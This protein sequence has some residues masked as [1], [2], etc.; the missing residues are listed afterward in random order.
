MFEPSSIIVPEGVIEFRTDRGECEIE[1]VGEG[2]LEPFLISEDQPG[3]VKPLPPPPP[4]HVES[5]VIIDA[6]VTACSL[7]QETVVRKRIQTWSA[8]GTLSINLARTDMEGRTAVSISCE[9][10][11]LLVLL[12]LIKAGASLVDSDPDGF[13]PLHV[14][15]KWGRSEIVLALLDG[16]SLPC[17]S[18]PCL[19]GSTPL[20]LCALN[21][22]PEC[23]KLLCLKGADPKV[24]DESGRTPLGCGMQSKVLRQRE[25]GLLYKYE[26]EVFRVKMSLL[27]FLCLR[28]KIGSLPCSK[29]CN[30]L[31][32]KDS[33]LLLY[34][35]DANRVPGN[36]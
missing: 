15:C 19:S 34:E 13:T 26:M 24:R 33:W 6:F 10:G 28:L 35:S 16:G 3:R 21:G 5:E 4:L 29:V 31:L 12:T 9:K 23:L 32:S 25:N 22:H 27:V 36:V 11:H 20:H 1:E 2:T 30:Y 17:L 8:Q 14:A 7:G 18:R